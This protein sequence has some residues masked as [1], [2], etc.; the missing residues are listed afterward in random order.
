MIF[1]GVRAAVGFERSIH[2]CREEV[3]GIVLAS[4]VLA[5]HFG[6]TIHEY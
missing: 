3:L 1:S 5:G 2:R 6:L 4:L